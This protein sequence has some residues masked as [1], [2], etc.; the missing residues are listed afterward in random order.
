[1]AKVRTNLPV[2][3]MVWR[4]VWIPLEDGTR[5]SAR[6]W[7]PKDAVER[8]V[9]AI[10]E[11][12]PYRKT[13]VC[14]RKD[15]EKHGYFAAHGYACVRVDL[16]GSGD[17]DGLLLDEYLPQELQDGVEVINW[18][19]CQPWCTG[20]VGMI[21][22]SWGGFNALQIAALA[23]EPLK[24]VVSVGSTDD[25]YADDIHYWGGTL[26]A[27]YQLFWATTMLAY[28]ARPGDPEVVGP[29]WR[30]Q[31][32][33]RL[34]NIRPFIQPWM[35][36]QR[37]DAYWKHGSV[38]EDYNAMKCAIY[39]VGAWNDGYT[40]S[41]FRVLQGYKG[42]CKGLIG[43]WGHQRPHRGAPGPA[44]GFL[45]ESVRWWD[46]WLKGIDNGIMAEPRLRAYIEDATPPRGRMTVWPGRWVGDAGYPDATTKRAT[47]FLAEAGLA[48]VG[49]PSGTRDHLATLVP[50]ADA[51]NWAG[52]G[53]AVDNAADQRPE[54]ANWLCFDSDP[55]AEAIDIFGN[56]TLS[57]R[58][59][60]DRPQANVIARLC[61]VA[62]DGRST[63]ITRGALNLTHR[64]SRE[65]PQDLIPGQACD[66]QV[67]LKAIGYRVPPGHRLRIALSS[68]Y[69]PWAWPSPEPVTLCLQT[70]EHSALSLPIR[71]APT[72]EPAV[73][74]HFAEPEM[75]HDD[76]AEYM[77]APDGGRLALLDAGT[78]H[79][80]IRDNSVFFAGIRLPAENGLEYREDGE[81]ALEITEGDPLSAVARSARTC[82]VK[83]G[84]W[85]TRVESSAVMT[86]TRTEFLVTSSIEA[87]EGDTRVFAKTWSDRFARDHL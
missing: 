18:I 9:P 45:Q 59:S 68:S 47:Y 57:L 73:P 5:L 56:P 52:W 36:H 76:G 14:A 33:H 84:D 62:P 19:A 37:H 31:W 70:G 49:G 16:R 6:I 87:F 66:V 67:T 75:W 35:T 26:F 55:L 46:Y 34:E 2:E 3:I 78:G 27:R 1:M 86:S 63:L 48:A 50:A 85:R 8:P 28:N 79:H 17:S 32:M 42:P 83:R 24:A 60:A 20:K 4:H 12:I 54:D 80:I 30:D 43:P 25:R 22:L 65:R 77:T 7:L 82:H 41:V 58:L 72:A 40:N 61:D 11:Y 29:G 69:W 74:A 51:G 15:S 38:R 81:D 39:M 10:L 71:T 21:G 53:H 13:D 64:N 44:I 23:P